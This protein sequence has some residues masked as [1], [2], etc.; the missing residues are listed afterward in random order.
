V[1]WKESG[2]NREGVTAGIDEEGALLVRTSA[3]IE[4]IVGG[5]LQWDS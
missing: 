5:E 1:R 3:G 2:G 4:R